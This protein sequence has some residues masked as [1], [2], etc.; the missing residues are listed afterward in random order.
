MHSTLQHD[1]IHITNM[2]LTGA[3]Y[4]SGA[5]MP[6][7]PFFTML[8]REIRDMIYMLAHSTGDKDFKFIPL[9]RWVK[10][11]RERRRTAV[12]LGKKLSPI[13]PAVCP[14]ENLQV[15]RQYYDEATVTWFRSK[16]I[17]TDDVDEFLKLTTGL[18]RIR[19][20]LLELDLMWKAS[21]FESLSP[22]GKLSKFQGLR[23]LRLRVD[24]SVFDTVSSK[25]ACVHETRAHDFGDMEDVQWLLEKLQ[26][27]D[28]ITMEAC[29][30]KIATTD[31]ERE[32]WKKNVQHLQFYVRDMLERKAREQVANHDEALQ[33]EEERLS[34]SNDAELLRQ[35]DV[36]E[37]ETVQETGW[38]P[39]GQELLNDVVE[40]DLEGTHNLPSP[41]IQASE[42]SRSVT[43]TLPTYPAA[44]PPHLTGAFAQDYPAM[45]RL[46]VGLFGYCVVLTVALI[47]LACVMLLAKE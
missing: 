41:S 43:A 18:P 24:D 25:L 9:S 45:K 13:P 11:E 5:A 2:D 1:Q 16:T 34:V 47:S 32:I 27:L 35:G 6:T 28:E 8:P 23:R 29:K 36:E 30:S 20:N 38:Q 3:S 31:C 15:C 42:S 44:E 39:L 14:L 7:A 26:R 21:M 19:D 46:L 12:Y 33:G 40:E 4:E 17:S 22:F 37:Q 10:V